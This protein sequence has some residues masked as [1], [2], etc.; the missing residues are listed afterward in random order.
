MMRLAVIFE[1]SPFD[2]KGL[3]NAVHNRVKHLLATGECTIDVFCVHSRDNAFTRRVRHT[4]EVPSVNETV[5]DGIRYR[6]LW[7]RFSILD[8]VLLEKLHVRPWLFRRFMD[9]HVDLLKGYDAVIAHSFCGGLFALAAHERFGVPFYVTWHGSDVHTHPWRVPVILEDTRA[10]MK[11]ARCNFF[12]S[13][14]LLDASERIISANDVLPVSSG[15]TGGA[16]AHN[17]VAPFVHDD[18]VSGVSS[19]RK[20]VLYN[21]VSEEF[22]KYSPERRAAVRE[23]YGLSVED[24]VVAFVGNLVAVKNVLSLPDI[25][26]KV[27]SRFAEV[28]G[29]LSD[30]CGRSG[31]LKFWIVGDGK[32]RSQLE[33]ACLESLTRHCE[34][35]SDVAISFF[36]NQPSSAMPDIMNCIDVLVLP[37]LNEGLPLVC[38]EALSCGAAVVGSDVGGIAEVIGSDN[39]VPLGDSFVTGMAEKVVT[40]LVCQSPSQTLP[41]D[42]SWA[43]TA[44]LELAALKS[45]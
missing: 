39:V 32:L 22:V 43:R 24:K 17:R 41:A 38:A 4:P 40:A 14:A 12:V 36:G 26:A 11:S 29:T 31:R 30:S 9:L 21:G 45:L 15:D 1:S 19:V 33:T 28:S 3:F 16:Q 37:S 13:R 6:L 20:E 2:R 23:R 18:T 35:R 44:T 34:E 7:Y 5:V 42:I 25:F 10:V 27:A 8:N